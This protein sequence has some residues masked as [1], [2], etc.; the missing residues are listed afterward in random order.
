MAPVQSFFELE[1]KLLNEH[2]G[3][4]V[5]FT[6]LVLSLAVGCFALLAALR[7]TLIASATHLLF[8]QLAYPMLLVSILS[9]LL[10][11]HRIMMNPIWHLDTAKARQE[12]SVKTGDASPV[13]LRR[14][15]SAMERWI[16]R[17]QVASF[18]GAFLVLALY[19]YE[20]RA[21]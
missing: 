20:S 7:E 3:H 19:L 18:V 12:E 6:R 17:V 14:R 21:T 8:V 16:Y 11:Q 9:G 2:H 5:T 1:Q 4:Y 13:E 10:V 15:P